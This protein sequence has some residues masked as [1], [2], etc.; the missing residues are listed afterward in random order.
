MKMQKKVFE[1]TL[2]EAEDK[3]REL[4]DKLAEKEKQIQM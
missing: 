1:K 4:T 3:V 2:S